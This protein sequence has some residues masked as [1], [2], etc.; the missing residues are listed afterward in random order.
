MPCY[1]MQTSSVEWSKTTNPDLLE[2]ALQS[3][4]YAT[5][6]SE[7]MIYFGNSTYS[8]ADGVMNLPRRQA[9]EMNKRIK[10][11]YAAQVAQH[12]FK[13][14]GWTVQE[15]KATTVLMQRR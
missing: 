2:K 11:A 8:I 12:A 4:N 9:E 10:A 15:L 6:R 3:L 13:S 14:A 7:G 5:S 1:S